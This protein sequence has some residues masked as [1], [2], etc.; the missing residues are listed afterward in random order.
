LQQRYRFFVLVARI[1]GG[2]VPTSARLIVGSPVDR[3]GKRHLNRLRSERFR[4]N[5]SY[6]GGGKSGVVGRGGIDQ[7][8]F[9]RSRKLRRIRCIAPCD[10]GLGFGCCE[11]CFACGHASC[12]DGERLAQL[13]CLEA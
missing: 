9:S 12:G 10:G 5:N 13:D 6:S 7:S 2:D 11:V 8:R 4:N 3:D 1:R